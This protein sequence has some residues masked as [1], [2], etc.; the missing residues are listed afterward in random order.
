MLAR[1]AEGR[2]ASPTARVI[3]SQSVKTTE[4]YRREIVRLGK[5][6][7]RGTGNHPLRLSLGLNLA[8]AFSQTH[9][10][11]RPVAETIHQRLV[12]PPIDLDHG[13]VDH[14]HKRRC[15][16]H[17]QT[18]HLI[19][20]GNAAK[21]DRGWRQLVSLLIGNLHVARHRLDETSPALG[22]HGPGFTATK[23]TLSLP[24]WPAS[25]SVRFC[26]AAF[27]APGQISQ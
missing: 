2:E 13:S 18:G 27:A 14:V 16:H 26:P 3:D 24:Y 23:L 8:Q 5:A 10:P 7:G 1:E 6:G 25:E 4:R 12:L 11:S 15:Q 20:L 21:R 22:A 17:D 9:S 19:D